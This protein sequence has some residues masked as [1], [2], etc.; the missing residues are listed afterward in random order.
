LV[1]IVSILMVSP[2]PY[3]KTSRLIPKML[4]QPFTG[5]LFF[6]ATVI[7]MLWKPA[8]AL[9]PIMLFYTILGPVEWGIF[10]IKRF[11][12]P[13]EEAEDISESSIPS[14]RRKFRRR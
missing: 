5:R 14:N 13:T 2:I 11:R 7:G 4:Q 10:H 9:F 6:V 12:S 3:W 1:P 8:L